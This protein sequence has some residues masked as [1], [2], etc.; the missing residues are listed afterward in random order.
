MGRHADVLLGRK[1]RDPLKTN[2]AGK[3]IRILVVDD[4]EVFRKFV[5]SAL[6]GQP[7]L[8]IIGEVRDGIEAVRQAEALQPDLILL[9]IGLPSL[10]GIAAARQIGQLAPCARIIFVSQESSP[11]VVQEAFNLGALAFVVKR[12]AGRELLAAIDA[13]IQGKKF[14]S[15]GLDGEQ[16]HST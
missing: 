13:V 12:L 7:D 5:M 15:T 4:H 3:R 1:Y 8:D 6:H 11:E 16:P 9:D 14:L 2:S 10:N